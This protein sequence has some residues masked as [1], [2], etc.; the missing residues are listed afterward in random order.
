MANCCRRGSIGALNDAP[1]HSHPGDQ[2]VVYGSWSGSLSVASPGWLDCQVLSWSRFA[3]RLSSTVCLLLFLQAST[4]RQCKSIHV[5][6]DRLGYYNNCLPLTQATPT[7]KLVGCNHRRDRSAHDADGAFPPKQAT[8]TQTDCMPA[9]QA[10]NSNKA[11]HLAL[12]VLCD[13]QFSPL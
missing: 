11:G 7:S 3:S 12:P 10:S 13:T 8:Q 1:P 6:N 9:C 4:H 2:S 5:Q